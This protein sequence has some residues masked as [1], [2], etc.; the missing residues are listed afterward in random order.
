MKKLHIN[1]VQSIRGLS[2]DLYWTVFCSSR[3]W[4]RNLQLLFSDSMYKQ[5]VNILFRLQTIEILTLY[6][7]DT[8]FIIFHSSIINRLQFAPPL[9]IW[10]DIVILIY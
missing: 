10:I 2:S 1:F 7:E 8:N 9:L 6:T 5:R 3:C 4:R